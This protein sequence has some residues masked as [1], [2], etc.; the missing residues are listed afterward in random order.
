MDF[1]RFVN[2]GVFEEAFGHIHRGVQGDGP[3]IFVE[4]DAV[5]FVARTTEGFD[6]GSGSRVRLGGIGRFGR[7][8]GRRGCRGIFGRS[9]QG[10]EE[11]GGGCEQG[12][13]HERA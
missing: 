9:G 8:R 13:H 1:A 2:E 10:A 3:G 4:T 6:G 7:R 11:E 5:Q 12:F